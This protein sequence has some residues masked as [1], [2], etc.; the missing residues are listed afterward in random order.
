V[1]EPEGRQVARNSGQPD[2]AKDFKRTSEDLHSSCLQEALEY[3]A[4]FD[5]E[6]ASETRE[7]RKYG[8]VQLLDII[9]E[10]KVQHF[11]NRPRVAV[12]NTMKC[13]RVFK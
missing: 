7:A 12:S 1:D 5:A 10:K 6:L 11:E 2:Y 9:W 8:D 4:K 3:F 13:I